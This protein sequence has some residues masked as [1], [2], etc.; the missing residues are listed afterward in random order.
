MQGAWQN[1]EWKS[2]PATIEPAGERTIIRAMLPEGSQL[3][4]YLAVKDSRDATV[5]TRHAELP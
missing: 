4:Y 3:V 2:L 5:S 1:R